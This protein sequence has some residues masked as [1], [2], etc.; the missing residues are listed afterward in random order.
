MLERS[1]ALDIVRLTEASA[2]A[3]ARFMGAGDEA[4]ADAAAVEAMASSLKELVIDGTVV[5]G[6]GTAASGALLPSGTRVGQGE[7]HLDLALDALE[8]TNICATGGPNAMSIVAVGEPGSFLPVP[9]VYM[10]KLV[11][12]PGARGAINLSR[13]LKENLKNV[14][15]A[16]GKSIEELTVVVLDRPRNKDAIDAIRRLSAR[17]RLIGDGDVSSAIATAMADSGVDCL[18]GMGGAPQG[19]LSAVALKCVGGDFQGQLKFRDPAESDAAAAMGLDGPDR[20]LTIDDLARG[21][22]L[23]F[24]A[25]GV[26]DGDLLKGVRFVP[27]AA[28]T[29]SLVLALRSRVIRRIESF[30]AI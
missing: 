9:E 11:V 30:H 24:V 12:G 21:E 6:E 28:Y 27:G 2:L 14:A 13:P 25:T 10:E 8:G 17:L 4:A 5:L 18:V 22:D 20:A 15:G 1:L 23:V 26:T 29:Q 16:L 3:S 19:V 7:L